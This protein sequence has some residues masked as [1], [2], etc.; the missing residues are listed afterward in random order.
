MINRFL[1]IFKDD[2]Q[3]NEKAIVGFCAF[4]IMVFV[5]FVDVI[6]GWFGNDLVI[7][8]FIYNSFVIVVL[9]AFG[10]SGIEKIFKK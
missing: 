2:N 3:W 5:I 4:V 8:E 6:S 1:E 9:G 7:N 10:I